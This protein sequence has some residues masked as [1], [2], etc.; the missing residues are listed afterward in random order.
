LDNLS[1]RTI[2]R[3]LQAAGVFARNPPNWLPI[4]ADVAAARVAF[5]VD[6]LE[7][8]PTREHW[9][10][11][12]FS[13]EGQ[14]GYQ[15]HQTFQARGIKSQPRVRQ[16]QTQ[17]SSEQGSKR[18]AKGTVRCWAAVG[19]GF[20][21][22]LISYTMTG[23]RQQRMTQ[24]V[25]KTEILGTVVQ[26]WIDAGQDFILEED[27]EPGHGPDSGPMKVYKQ[28]MGLVYYVN[29]AR[30]PDLTPFGSYWD[31]LKQDMAEFGLATT[32]NV[33]QFAQERWRELDQMVIDRWVDDMPQR[34]QAVIDA[35]GQ[36]GKIH[37]IIQPPEQSLLSGLHEYTQ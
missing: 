26:G 20:K 31:L 37:G 5:T 34:L 22:D 25:Y 17:N 36:L 1:H 29:C 2:Q 35:E 23:S 19:F 7:R 28:D 24:N 11:V 33:F 3:G 18:L 8:L 9:R 16:T 21:S 4:D 15:S 13:D 10:K 12:R 27:N 30:S 6:M 32:P 14:L